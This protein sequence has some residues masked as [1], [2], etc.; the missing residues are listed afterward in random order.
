MFHSTQSRALVSLVVTLSIVLFTWV[1]AEASPVPAS[2]ANSYTEQKVVAADGAA[3]DGY[4]YAVAISDDG[5]TALVGTY[6]QYNTTFP[7]GPGDVYVYINNGGTWILQQKLT[8]PAM[9][10]SDEFGFSVAISAD[11][12][13]ALIGAKGGDVATN[14]NQGAAYIFTRSS[15]TW[16]QQALLTAADGAAGDRFGIS[17]TLSDDGNTAMI[18]AYVD[19]I[20]TNTDQGSVY[21]FVRSGESWSQQTHLTSSDGAAGDY[22]GRSVSLSGDGNTA[23]IGANMKKIGSNSGQGSAYIF[24]RSGTSWSQQAQLIPLDGAAYDWL[25][26]S[27]SI[28]GDGNTALAGAEGHKVGANSTQGAA[29]IFTRSG[30]TWSER[31]QLAALD[32]EES[33]WFGSAVALASSGNTALIGAHWDMVGSLMTGSAYIFSGSGSSWTQTAHLVA[34]DAASGDNFGV[35]VA[36]SGNG[37]IAF[38]GADLAHVSGTADQGVAYFFTTAVQD[39]FIFLP[40]VSR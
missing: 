30:T 24:T 31:A 19:D 16:N 9:P 35:A 11:G 15:S 18:G 22:F 40:M 39:H 6:Y 23:A 13:T 27:V 8:P 1:C 17:A 7:I 3:S 20:A 21:I 25:G 2:V 14:T 37:S 29:Y 4:G 10:E 33:D 36:L 32:G 5:S 28:S 12:N 34:S 26:S 38:T